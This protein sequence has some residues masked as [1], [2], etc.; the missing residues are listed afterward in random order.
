MRVVSFLFSL[1]VWPAA[2]L[3]TVFFSTLAVLLSPFAPS[4]RPTLSLAHC[5][6]HVV[7]LVAGVRLRVEGIDALDPARSYVFMANH[8]SLA[9]IPAVIAAVPPRFGTRI[10]AKK[11][12]F[13]MPFLGWAMKALGFVAVDRKDRSTAPGMFRQTLGK[14]AAGNSVLLFPEETRTR[15]GRLLPFQRGGFLLA[16]KSQLPIVPIGIEGARIL[17]PPEG[18]LFRPF[19]TITVRIGTPIPTEGL[20]ASARPA[21][22]AATRAAVDRLRGSAG[23]IHDQETQEATAAPS[24]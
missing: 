2:V 7:L 16:L 4:G 14:V 3:V 17:L 15:D 24:S 10:L 18:R 19:T 23:H 13:S 9:D 12:L 22:M 5:W 11:S 1:F 21:L 20:G 8:E 6:A